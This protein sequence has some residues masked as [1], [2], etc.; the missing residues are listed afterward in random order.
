MR[1]VRKSSI[2]VRNPS[3][4]IKKTDDQEINDAI[5]DGIDVAQILENELDFNKLKIKG[6]GKIIQDFKSL[7]M[8]LSPVLQSQGFEGSWKDY[9]GE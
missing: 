8:M 7:M 6:A 5:H 9:R 1:E 4:G 2:D 3:F